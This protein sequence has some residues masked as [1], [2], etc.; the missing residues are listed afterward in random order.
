MDALIGTDHFSN[1]EPGS[2][3]CT[4][5]GSLERTQHHPHSDAHIW[6]NDLTNDP[7]AY[8]KTLEISK[9]QRTNTYRLSLPVVSTKYQ[10]RGHETA[11]A[12]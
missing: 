1:Y 4:I 3:S 12:G 11:T 10:Q 9:N 8:V 5:P 7:V 2:I 6:P